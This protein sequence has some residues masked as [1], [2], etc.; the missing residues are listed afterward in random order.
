MGTKRMES[1]ARYGRRPLA[2]GEVYMHGKKLTIHNPYEAMKQ[3]IADAKSLAA[4]QAA[5][6]AHKAGQFG[7]VVNA[8]VTGVNVAFMAASLVS[9]VFKTLNR[10][11]GSLER[12]VESLV[13]L[14]REV[15]A[16]RIPRRGV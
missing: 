12:Y 5:T 9:I 2:S 15:A 10:Y 16:Y 14:R 11:N 8:T 4:H 1:P 7:K 6:A 3:G 13:Q